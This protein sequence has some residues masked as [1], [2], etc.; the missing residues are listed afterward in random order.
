MARLLLL[1]LLVPIAVSPLLGRETHCSLG[2][3]AFDSPYAGNYSGPYTAK[4]SD[5]GEQ[6]GRLTLSS[7][8]S[9]RVKG[10]FQNR[11]SGR[12]AD[13]TGSVTDDG[14][15]QLVLEWPDAT[16]TIKGTVVKTRAGHLKGTLNQYQGKQVVAVIE[17]DLLPT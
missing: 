12:T 17:I 2:I 9:G 4:S 8:S 5:Y 13:I 1:F 3:A 7:D 6:S 10:K 16:F 15:I 14:D 11:T